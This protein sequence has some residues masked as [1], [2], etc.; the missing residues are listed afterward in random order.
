VLPLA[1]GLG[2]R[3]RSAEPVTIK[4]GVLR[5]SLDHAGLGGRG[6]AAPVRTGSAAESHPTDRRQLQS[7][8][9][10][11]HSE[12]EAQQ[13]QLKP[14]VNGDEKAGDTIE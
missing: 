3:A 9:G 5:P 11:V 13:V 14:L 1:G 2:V 12:I 7:R 8:R 6:I 4:M 10:S